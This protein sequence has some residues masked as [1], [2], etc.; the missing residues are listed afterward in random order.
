M[1]QQR[2]YE[3]YADIYSYHYEKGKSFPRG[4]TAVAFSTA[5]SH[6]ML[7]KKW[8]IIA[9]SFLWSTSVAYSWLY[10]G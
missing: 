4:H 3:K 8:F 5:T 9:P 6:S 2:P 7:Y 10:L 1:N